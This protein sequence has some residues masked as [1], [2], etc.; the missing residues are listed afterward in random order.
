MGMRGINGAPDLPLGGSF[1]HHPLAFGC[2]RLPTRSVAGTLCHTSWCN[3]LYS[4]QKSQ[5]LSR[6]C[7]ITHMAP[8][9]PLFVAQQPT[10]YLP[11]RHGLHHAALQMTMTLIHEG[12][13]M[14]QMSGG[15]CPVTGLFVFCFWFLVSFVVF[16]FL[17]LIFFLKKMSFS[18]WIFSVLRFKGQSFQ[19][20][21]FTGNQELR[22]TKTEN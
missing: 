21:V 22:T 8:K 12:E 10:K 11:R 16:Q 19:F 9:K 17:V 2:R 13:T 1:F 18:V 5:P 15:T 3:Q 4:E 6:Q 14:K 7:F 20:M